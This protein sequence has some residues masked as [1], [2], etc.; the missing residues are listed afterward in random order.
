MQIANC[1]LV[2]EDD[3]LKAPFTPLVF[4]LADLCS[5]LFLPAS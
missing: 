3:I 4:H 1:K 5:S 2:I